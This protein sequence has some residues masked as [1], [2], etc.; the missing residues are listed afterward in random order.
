MRLV[1]KYLFRRRIGSVGFFLAHLR[2][3]W[4]G[5][6]QA[7]GVE[8]THRDFRFAVISQAKDI[9]FFMFLNHKIFLSISFLMPYSKLFYCKNF[10]RYS[11]KKTETMVRLFFIF[12]ICSN[13][14]RDF[15][16]CR[17][18]ILISEMIIRFFFP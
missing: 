13:I 15:S 17:R 14:F 6:K 12:W 1:I 4:G 18:S 5:G 10:R 11:E 3:G 16:D 9:Q 8:P 2:P 7:G